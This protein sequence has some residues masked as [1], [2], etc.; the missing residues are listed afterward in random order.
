MFDYCDDVDELIHDAIEKYLE[1]TYGDVNQ[2]MV[3]DLT[4]MTQL[5]LALIGDVS[6]DDA[7]KAAADVVADDKL[8][9]AD[10]ATFKQFIMGQEVVLGPQQ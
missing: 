1:L 4:D 9:L 6:L 7:Q 8:D 2:D 10:L 3:T 5:A